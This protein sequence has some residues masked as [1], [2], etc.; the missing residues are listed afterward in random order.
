[1]GNF[2]SRM[3]RRW[4]LITAD[5]FRVW[6][7]VNL[8]RQRKRW[9]KKDTYPIYSSNLESTNQQLGMNIKK[10]IMRLRKP[11]EDLNVLE[12]GIGTGET[13]RD[14]QGIEGVKLH[15]TN[16]KYE[17]GFRELR[18][19][20]TDIRICHLGQLEE[21]F[22]KS[23]MDLVFASNVIGHSQ[24]HRGDLEQISKIVATGGRLLF[25]E[26]RAKPKKITVE[27]L[28]EFGFRVFKVKT[29]EFD[30]EY[31][32]GTIKTRKLWRFFSKKI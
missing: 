12:I 11:G 20:G 29:M 28:R 5:R 31:P 8:G 23:S 27:I 16:L 25:N 24:N 13:L 6:K 17:Q 22:G 10:L 4:N 7:Q 19:R 9:R 26:L 30:F 18:E 2:L 21:K 32:D 3:R 1:M 15:G 14:L